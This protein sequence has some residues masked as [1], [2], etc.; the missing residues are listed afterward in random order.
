MKKIILTSILLFGISAVGLSQLPRNNDNKTKLKSS[1][2]MTDEKQ[3]FNSQEEK[4]QAIDRI[5]QLIELRISQGKKEEDLIN[6]FKELDKAK[7]AQ[8]LN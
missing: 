8:V 1:S 3:T 5:E 7:N 4:N 6:H 2:E